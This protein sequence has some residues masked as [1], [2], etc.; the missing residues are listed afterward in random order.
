MFTSVSMTLLSFRNDVQEIFIGDPGPFLHPG[1]CDATFTLKTALH[2]SEAT[3]PR[4]F[5][6]S[7][8]PRSEN[9]TTKRN[10][11]SFPV[12]RSSVRYNAL[13]TALLFRVSTGSR[14]GFDA[15]KSEYQK[16]T[17][18]WRRQLHVV[19]NASSYLRSE[20]ATFPQEC[21]G[22]A[23]FPKSRIPRETHFETETYSIQQNPRKEHT[24]TRISIKRV[25]ARLAIQVL[26]KIDCFINSVMIRALGA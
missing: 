6:I 21:V 16:R 12:P 5:I 9:V 26:T 2:K 17:A 19:Q 10:S 11:R 4:S 1:I 22:H 8:I 14:H 18:R 3:C 13:S 23:A 25:R 7:K 15:T 24:K 20:N